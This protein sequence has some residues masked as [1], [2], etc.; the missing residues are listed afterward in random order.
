MLVKTVMKWCIAF[1][2]TFQNVTLFTV[3]IHEHHAHVLLSC[4]SKVVGCRDQQKLNHKYNILR[5][6]IYFPSFT[7]IDLYPAGE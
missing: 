7:N 4:D 3:N 6:V 1:S 2:I 5:F